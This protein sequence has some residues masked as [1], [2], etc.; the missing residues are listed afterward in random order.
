[1]VI[2]GYSYFTTHSWKFISKRSQLLLEKLSENDRQI[3]YFDVRK[4]NW[5]DYMQN[6]ILGIRKFILKD[7]LSTMAK[8]RI[9]LSRYITPLKSFK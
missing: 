4:I 9:N 2:E 5:D 1:M 6:W 8:A 3:F 7:D